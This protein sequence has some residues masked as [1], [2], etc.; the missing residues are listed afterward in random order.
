MKKLATNPGNSAERAAVESDMVGRPSEHYVAAGSGEA[1]RTHQMRS[2]ALVQTVDGQCKA[3]H[4]EAGDDSAQ[5]MTCR[6]GAPNSSY[7]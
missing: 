3:A 6:Y 1:D 2:F 4:K 7:V 5:W